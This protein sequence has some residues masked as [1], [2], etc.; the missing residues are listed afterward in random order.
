VTDTVTAFG[1][2][3][4][5][6]KFGTPEAAGAA[7]QTAFKGHRDAIAFHPVDIGR[8]KIEASLTLTLVFA[9]IRILDL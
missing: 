5:D 3:P 6:I 9:Y 1:E 4:F 8:A 7:L 2:T